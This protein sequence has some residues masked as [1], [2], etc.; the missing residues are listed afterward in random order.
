[1]AQNATLDFY[2]RILAD[3]SKTKH[4]QSPPD[5]IMA[6]PKELKYLRQSAIVYPLKLRRR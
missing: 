5:A 3:L 1:M 4:K 6:S 2:P